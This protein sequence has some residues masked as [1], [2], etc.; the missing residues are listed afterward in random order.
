MYINMLND[1]LTLSIQDKCRYC[2]SYK[3]NTCNLIRCFENLVSPP[4]SLD[5]LIT[6]CE[7]YVGQE[8]DNLFYNIYPI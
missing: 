5:I 3:D 7:H 1:K 2:K 6:D 8:E 4:N